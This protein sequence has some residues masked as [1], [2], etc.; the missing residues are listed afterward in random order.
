M[1]YH[2]KICTAMTDTTQASS[3]SRSNASPSRRLHAPRASRSLDWRNHLRHQ[4]SSRNSGWRKS[5]RCALRHRR[6]W[7]RCSRVS[8]RAL[9]WELWG[10][11][12]GHETV[13]F[14]SLLFYSPFG[15]VMKCLYTLIDS[16]DTAPVRVLEE[17]SLSW[18]WANWYRSCW[19]NSRLSGLQKSLLGRYPPIFLRGKKGWLCGWDVYTFFFTYLIEF[20]HTRTCATGVYHWSCFAPK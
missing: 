11:I 12:E 17:T 7:R 5:C 8:A 13:L 4:P 9:A 14:R 18:S 3:N 16:S 6:L 19:E 1:P 10:A 15:W 20:I 2:S